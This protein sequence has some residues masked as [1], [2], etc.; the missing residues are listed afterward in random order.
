MREFL[1]EKFHAS[2]FDAKIKGNWEAEEQFINECWEMFG[3]RL[4]R[5]KMV[6]NKGLRALAKLC[7][8]NLWGRFSLRNYG[9]AQSYI[10]SD[11]AELGEYLDDRTIDVMAVDE[12][13]PETIMI[14]YV[15][16]KEFIDEHECSNVGK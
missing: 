6:P 4:D 9:L 16:K 11:P 7:V 10:T 8:N 14:S 5:S 15:K 1:T 2:G 3:M 13:T 12:L